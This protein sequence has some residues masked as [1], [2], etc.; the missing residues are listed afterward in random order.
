MKSPKLRAIKGGGHLSQV[1]SGKNRR[2]G[3]EITSICGT[4][5]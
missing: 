3:F 4:F 1:R 5:G 2:I